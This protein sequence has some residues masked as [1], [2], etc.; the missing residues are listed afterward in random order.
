M[1]IDDWTPPPCPKCHRDSMIHKC[2][3]HVP[4][5][6]TFRKNGWYCE[7][8][9]AGPFMLSKKAEESAVKLA[10]ILSAPEPLGVLNLTPR[11][12]AGT[13][14]LAGQELTM[15]HRLLDVPDHAT[16]DELKER[17]HNISMLVDFNGLGAEI[18]PYFFQCFIEQN[19]P[20]ST[21]LRDAL[22]DIGKEPVY[23]IEK[24]AT[25]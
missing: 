3:S 7:H 4:G 8:C 20:L 13:I 10:R 18:D 2:K 21:Y 9:D 23:L 12:V 11:P 14:S 5:T 22:I 16:F 1:N 15:L 6:S 24:A 25:S 19:T 17:A